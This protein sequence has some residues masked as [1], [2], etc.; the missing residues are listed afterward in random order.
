MSPDF[1]PGLAVKDVTVMFVIGRSIMRFPCPGCYLA[2]CAAVV[3][4]D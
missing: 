4:R 1:G 3:S 2:N